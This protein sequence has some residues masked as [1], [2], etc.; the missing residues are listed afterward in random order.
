MSVLLDPTLEQY[1]QPANLALLIVGQRHAGLPRAFGTELE[2]GDGERVLLEQLAEHAEVGGL[3][4][5]LVDAEPVHR[6]RRWT[7]TRE[8][9]EEDHLHDARAVI[10]AVRAEAVDDAVE[11]AP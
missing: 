2:P 6:R 1:V 4:P 7:L 5:R 8:R 9:G 11:R 10:V 3:R